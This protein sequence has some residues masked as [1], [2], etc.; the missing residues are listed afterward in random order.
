MTAGGEP[1]SRRTLGIATLAALGCALVVLVLVI[2]PAEYGIDPTGV[3][4]AIGLTVLDGESAPVDP[5]GDAPEATSAPTTIATFASS[6]ALT[7][8]PL[9]GQEGYLEEGGTLLVPFDVAAANVSE[10]RLGLEFDD[11]NV[12]PSGEGTRPD[13]FEIELTGP[14]GRSSGVVLAR[15]DP[16]SG[17]GGGRGRAR[18]PRAARPAGAGRGKRR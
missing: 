10:V 18:G 8:T 13:L 3:G 4:R 1:P 2:L 7:T 16:A 9:L 11:A 6:F 5:S 15:S 14:D 12:T 17:K